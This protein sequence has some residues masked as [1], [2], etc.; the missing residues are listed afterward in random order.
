MSAAGAGTSAAGQRDPAARDGDALVGMAIFLG[1]WVMLFAA[2]FFAYAVVRVQSGTEWPPFGAPRLPRGAAA[3]NTLLLGASSAALRLGL[4][5]AR[6]QGRTSSGAGD[7]RALGRALRPWLAATVL[8]GTAFLAA[9]IALWLTMRGRGLMPG[10][11]VYGSVFFALTGFHAI[12]VLGGVVALVAVAARG[13]RSAGAVATPLRAARLTAVY[14]DFM[15]VV[16]LAMY[17]A[18]FWI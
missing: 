11:G 13:A 16:W 14:W 2:L 7:A 10:S 8:L 6:R 1:A 18:I 15:A 4:A 12:H 3:L 17:V 5:R 9:Q